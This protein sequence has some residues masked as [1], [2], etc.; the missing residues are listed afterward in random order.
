MKISNAKVKSFVTGSEL[1]IYTFASPALIL[2][3]AWVSNTATIEFIDD[4][5]FPLQRL[6]FMCFFTILTFLLFHRMQP[7]FFFHLFDV[8]LVTEAYA[9]PCKSIPDGVFW[10]K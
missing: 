6:I 5:P 7:V 3:S 9:G 10:R 2:S 1:Y 4:V 8:W